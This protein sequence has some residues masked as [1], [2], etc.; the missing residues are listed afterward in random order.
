MIPEHSLH[1][2]S[3]AETGKHKR[4]ERANNMP[5]NSGS[6]RNAC[7][8]VLARQKSIA[9]E[10][11]GGNEAKNVVHPNGAGA[12]AAAVAVVAEHPPLA[13]P[14]VVNAVD[15]DPPLPPNAG[16]DFGQQA[17]VPDGVPP[18]PPLPPQQQ[19]RAGPVPVGALVP[20]PNLPP[21]PAVHHGV[22]PAPVA[23]GAY[24]AGGGLAHVANVPPPPPG[25]AGPLN[26]LAAG[27]AR[28]HVPPHPPQGP[29][30]RGPLG[31]GAGAGA[32]VGDNAFV[33]AILNGALRNNASGMHNVY[34]CTYYRFL[35]NS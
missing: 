32:G 25:A 35:F 28:L 7:F 5:I 6:F 29:P 17:A 14:A 33:A 22:Q 23:P 2:F 9:D 21:A 4:L 19:H 24:P 11:N 31:N 1:L 18:P 26:A 8:R 27:V 13:Q 15:G 34:L 12:N 16:Q 10:A 20:I 30:P 3:S